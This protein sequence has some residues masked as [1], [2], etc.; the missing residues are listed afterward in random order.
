[1][2]VAST[3]ELNRAKQFI[4]DDDIDTA[5]KEFKKLYKKYPDD[6]VIL[7]ELGTLLLRQGINVSEALYLLSL[8]TNKHNRYA[9]SNELGLYF[10][11]HGDYDKAIEKFSSLGSSSKEKD[12]CYGLYGLIMTYIHT[13]DYDKAL[14][15]FDKLKIL[16][17]ITEFDISHYYNLK[18]YL[19]T[20]NNLNP[21]EAYA[22]NYF[23]KQLVDYDKETAI[24]HIK[25]HLKQANEEKIKAKRVHSVFNEN[26]DIE[27]LYDYCVEI[28][29]DKDPTGRGE[30]DYYKCKLED[31][32]GVTYAN[33]E[34]TYVEVVTFPN[35]KDILSIYPVF[36]G[37]VNK[38]VEQN[39][40]ERKQVNKKNRKKKIYKKTKK[41]H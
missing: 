14:D 8:A 34:T 17:R 25:E 7:Y 36:N 13:G 33:K 12:R 1:M 22:D 28:I 27:K 4:I 6:N 23:R 31:K 37:H 40:K 20:K 3:Q 39:E 32:V 26:M 30:V 10:L 24:E 41:N 19:L 9:I 29:K 21:N 35:S 5:I 38:V 18:F 11:N 16:R 2:K 15:C